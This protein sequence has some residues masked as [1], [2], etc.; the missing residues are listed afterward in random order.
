MV[1]ATESFETALGAKCHETKQKT[2]A[3]Q[4]AQSAVAVL[5]S[6]KPRNS[7]T[8]AKV[9]GRI[10][11]V[12]DLADRSQGHADCALEVWKHLSRCARSGPLRKAGL[13]SASFSSLDE[14]AR[15]LCR[16]ELSGPARVLA[17]QAAWLRQALPPAD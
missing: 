3:P 2:L 8:P 14:G 17:Q 9:P 10:A 5:G 1:S 7:E 11:A 6:P 12:V 4:V 15:G 16:M 13:V